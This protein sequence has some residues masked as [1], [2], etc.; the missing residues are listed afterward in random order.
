[1]VSSKL[2]F[3][4]F[5]VFSLLLVLGFAP[6]RDLEAQDGGNGGKKP[7]KTR[8]ELQGFG[9]G[10]CTVDSVVV[11]VTPQVGDPVVTEFPGG[12]TVQAKPGDTINLTGST[13]FISN[14]PGPIRDVIPLEATLFR[15]G[16]DATSLLSPTTEGFTYTFT[17]TIAGS[18]VA[19]VICNDDDDGQN[20]PGENTMSQIS[21][22]IQVTEDAGEPGEQIDECHIL[23]TR[24]GDTE[25]R[26][27][28]DDKK[29]D[30][31]LQKEN[32]RRFPIEN[33][34]DVNRHQAA[35]ALSKFKGSSASC[36]L[37]T[38]FGD[39]LADVLVVGKGLESRRATENTTLASLIKSNFD[40][41]L[42]CCHLVQ[43]RVAIRVFS[44]VI[45]IPKG[46]LGDDESYE[47]EIGGGGKVSVA[48]IKVNSDGC[49]DPIEVVRRIT[50]EYQVKYSSEPSGGGTFKLTA[51]VTGFVTTEVFLNGIQI[52]F[53]PDQPTLTGHLVEHIDTNE[54]NEVLSFDNSITVVTRTSAGAAVAVRKTEGKPFLR[55]R[56]VNNVEGRGRVP[57]RRVF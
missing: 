51:D 37:K 55:A 12:G 28:V 17:P 29:V 39:T 31:P 50:S 49:G 24:E 53:F 42:D 56:S 48:E 27:E 16:S 22:T 25:S 33:D 47:G 8:I 40:P 54:I 19:T 23:G 41:T 18:Y 36:I 57:L 10:F 3:G 11:T 32:P 1:M 21:I 20:T 2:R 52:V 45:V 46:K 43:V 44:F 7:K 14:E 6:P 34:S 30:F 13:S 9:F 5:S 26:C 38:A 4:S 15:D 35:V